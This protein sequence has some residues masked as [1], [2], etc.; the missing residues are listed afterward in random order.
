M[1]FRS[2][3]HRHSHT[4]RPELLNSPTFYI[5]TPLND[6][7]EPVVAIDKHVY[8]EYFLR[9]TYDVLNRKQTLQLPNDFRILVEDVYG[10]VP[11]ELSPISKAA[12]EKLL[13]DEELARQEA[14][15]RLIP[16]PDPVEL[17]TGP[18]ARL[19]FIENETK[20]SWVV[21]KTRLGEK[22]LNVIP[23]EDLGDLFTFPGCTKPLEKCLTASRDIELSI[24]R[25]QI[26]I[27]NGE[28]VE[29]LISHIGEVPEVFKGSPL[30]KDY[31]PLWLKDGCTTISAKKNEFTVMLD[32]ELGL[33]FN[34]KG[35]E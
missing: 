31:V 27:S 30:L 12:Y 32:P 28:I 1:L 9:R 20:A 23:L 25:R 33:M 7:S 14:F 16:V 21:A 29:E 35:G 19:S 34:K 8:A 17:F 10:D 6:T 15:L 26:R 18:A 5:N 24:L 22:S 4:H 13:N 11:V 3:L 2:R